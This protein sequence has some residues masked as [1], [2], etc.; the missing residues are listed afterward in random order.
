MPAFSRASIRAALIAA[1]FGADLLADR[2]CRCLGAAD[3][4]TG[5]TRIAASLLRTAKTIEDVFTGGTTSAAWVAW[6]RIA[7]GVRHVTGF[8][9]TH[10]VRHANFD[11]LADRGRH[12]FGDGVRHLDANRV[13][14]RLANGVRH[15][16]TH[17]LRLQRTNFRRDVLDAF[18]RHELARGFLNGPGHL[19]RDHSAN[20]VR[21]LLDVSFLDR[22]SHGVRHTNHSRLGHH[23][24]RGVDDIA[25]DKSTFDE[26]TAV[27]GSIRGARH[28]CR[29]RGRSRRL[30]RRCVVA[31][32]HDALT[33]RGAAASLPS[34]RVGRTHPATHRASSH[35]V[36]HLR[37][38][39]FCL[40]ARDGVRNLLSNRFRHRPD[41][42]NGHLLGDRHRH[43][44]ANG[45]WHFLDAALADHRGDR[46]LLTHR[47]VAGDQPC[48]TT[49]RLSFK[50]ERHNFLAAFGRTFASARIGARVVA[51]VTLLAAVE[52][53]TQPTG[54]DI[55][56]A[57]GFGD[58]SNH[59][60]H[61]SARFTR[62][63][64]HIAVACFDTVLPFRATHVP[65]DSLANLLANLLAA[66]AIMRF[67]NRPADRSANIA[68]LRLTNIMAHLVALFVAMDLAHG[69]A[70]MLHHILETGLTHLLAN[71]IGAFFVAGFVNG[72]TYR[73]LD[74]TAVRF[75]MPFVDGVV[76][77]FHDDLRH[78][79]SDAALF[80]SPLGFGA[81]LVAGALL[82]AVAGLGDRLHHRLANSLMA[83]MEPFFR[84]HIPDELVASPSLLLAGIETTLGVARGLPQHTKAGV[85]AM[86]RLQRPGRPKQADRRHH[87]GRTQSNP[88]DP[89][90]LAGLPEWPTS[91]KNCFNLG[92]KNLR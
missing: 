18:V 50:S 61:R 40:H 64:D 34:C 52:S 73:L 10:I 49:I 6:S 41:T 46:H 48:G 62:P 22:P 76:A 16:H 90:L 25:D 63:T 1:R 74:L 26:D 78:G 11:G 4:A 56:L 69:F 53:H 42:R 84:G 27:T 43:F 36:W 2:I 12:H 85:A 60:L 88:H 3:L 32:F 21:H 38:N 75:V 57:D 68:K 5:L 17:H 83:Y 81:L 15:F 71:G 58:S 37:P 86:G 14:N 82:G 31:R 67:A 66:F 89:G 45:D 20:G 35:G 77:C 29:S 33:A 87:D 72:F 8:P 13:R 92:W 19:V 54:N 51:G 47:T 79:A 30:I 23:A 70:A 65:Q 39:D 59:S 80:G 7:N 24:G 91:F 44:L 9:H 28:R 55:V